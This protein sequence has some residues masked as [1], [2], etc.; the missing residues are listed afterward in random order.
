MIVHVVLFRPKADLG[1]ADRSALAA[2]IDRARR[3]IPEIRFAVGRR[4]FRETNYA[5]DMEDFPFVA[6]LEFD[7]AAALQ[8]YLRHP[9]HMEL[10]RLFWTTSDKALAY[11][12]DLSAGI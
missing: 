11:D 5:R 12:F 10:S 9:V 1:A 7:D 2:A 3:E 6:L 8:A 4:T